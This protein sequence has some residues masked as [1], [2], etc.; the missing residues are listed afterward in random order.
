MSNKA[1]NEMNQADIPG[2]NGNKSD[3]GLILYLN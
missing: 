1:I 2:T 3:L